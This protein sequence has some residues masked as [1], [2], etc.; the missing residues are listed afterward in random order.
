MRGGRWEVRKGV[1]KGVRT[2]GERNGND[3]YTNES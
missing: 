1:G 2:K 3:R